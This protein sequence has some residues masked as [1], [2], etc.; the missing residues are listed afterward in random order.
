LVCSE[1]GTGIFEGEKFY[2]GYNGP[3]CMDCLEDMTVSE[4]V[5][6]LGEKL[7]TAEVT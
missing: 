1:C 7:T 6:L 5:E 2:D 3:V 4:M